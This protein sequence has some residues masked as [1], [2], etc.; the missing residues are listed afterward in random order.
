MEHGGN[1]K[2][3]EYLDKYDLNSEDIKV[4]YNTKAAQWY[5]KRLA[6]SANGIIDHFTDSELEYNEGKKLADGRDSNPQKFNAGTNDS[7]NKRGSSEKE[8][9]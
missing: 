2:L 5:R 9:E 4:K 8:R 1:H 6:A 7:Q 3:S